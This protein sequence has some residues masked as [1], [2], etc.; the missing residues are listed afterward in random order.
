MKAS[1]EEEDQHDGVGLEGL[2]RVA[3]EHALGPPHVEEAKVDD[4]AVHRASRQCRVGAVG[5][6]PGEDGRVRLLLS[7][8]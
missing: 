1:E 8:K 3:L 4:G 5:A 2:A 7:L 6:L